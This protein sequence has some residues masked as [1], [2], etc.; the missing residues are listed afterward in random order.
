MFKGGIADK[1]GNGYESKWIVKYLLLLVPGKADWFK[2]EGLDT[3][4]AGFEFACN[5]NGRTE[6][7]Q[8]KNNCPTGNWSINALGSKGVLKAFA[9]RLGNDCTAHCFFVSQDTAKDF[10]TLSE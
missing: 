5:I 10:R 2:F 3:E 6:W 1:L 7:H 4:Y 8:T 9:N